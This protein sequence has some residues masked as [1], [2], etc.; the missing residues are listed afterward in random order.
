MAKMWK[1]IFKKQQVSETNHVGPT[2]HYEQQQQQQQQLSEAGREELM[3]LSY[4]QQQA[5][6]E[7][8]QGGP[9]TLLTGLQELEEYVS[10]HYLNSPAPFRFLP[11]DRKS[12]ILDGGSQP[13]DLI[14][15]YRNEED[16]TRQIPQHWHYIGFGL[17]DIHGYGMSCRWDRFMR[18]DP[19]YAARTEP[20]FE[21]YP[22]PNP[23]DPDR[24]IDLQKPIHS[25]YGIELTMRVAFQSPEE[26][27]PKWPA[28]LMQAL[29]SFVF[30][31][32]NVYKDGDH[33]AWVCPLD[34]ENSLIQHLLMTLDP[35]LG[36]TNTRYGKVKYIQL[37]GVCD[38][39]LQAAREWR[40]HGILDMLRE[41][42][43]F[44]GPY[45]V[46]DMSRYASIFILNPELRERVEKGIR[47]QGSGMILLSCKHK[48]SGKAPDWL[49]EKQPHQQDQEFSS[50]HRENDENTVNQVSGVERGSLLTMTRDDSCRQD[51]QDNMLPQSRPPSRMSCGSE[52]ALH[53][54]N[55]ELAPDRIYPSMYLLLPIEAFRILPIVLK[56]VLA[57]KRHFTYQSFRGD[58]ATT[59]VPERCE[60][61]GKEVQSLVH[62]E[63]RYRKQGVWLQI[64]VS[65]DMREQILEKISED[66][67]KGSELQLPKSYEWPDYNFHITV[68]NDIED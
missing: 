47:E 29:A 28:S 10:Q 17:S 8:R 32:K 38:E 48:Y 3:A 51:Q 45:L 19:E 62:P 16:L 50:Y 13:L 52:S 67:Q 39:E 21:I 68:V 33:T 65:D 59:F 49:K 54:E 15:V 42:S 36:E 53:L 18:L 37:V 31:S 23:I 4:Q 61:S 7:H 27:P 41:R 35:Q 24:P 6:T 22:N 64:F 9:T 60:N 57:H 11:P 55:V 12:F 30:Q 20:L 5:T 56:G 66:I 1:K 58:L 34:G 44:G 40:T 63:C 2:T 43:D 25:G 14:L 46:T 26:E